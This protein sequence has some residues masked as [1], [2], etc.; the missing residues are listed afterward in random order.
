MDVRVRARETEV[1]T[2]LEPAG[3]GQLKIIM[4]MTEE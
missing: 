1:V 2:K 3:A 4:Q